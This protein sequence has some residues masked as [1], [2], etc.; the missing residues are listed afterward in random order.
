VNIILSQATNRPKLRNTGTTEAPVAKI[1]AGP[2][3]PSNL[4]PSV[5]VIANA[6]DMRT[7]NKPE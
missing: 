5:V 3:N 7:K 2:D 1:F 4:G 6:A